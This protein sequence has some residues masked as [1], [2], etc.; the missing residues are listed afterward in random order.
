MQRTEI[1]FKEIDKEIKDC[2]E[3]ISKIKDKIYEFNNGRFSMLANKDVVYTFE[4][5]LIAS[6]DCLQCLY[7]IKR[8]Q[9]EV[10]IYKRKKK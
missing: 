6:Q 9:G 8:L 10:K 4:M 3:T 5:L 1:N 7:E 2:E